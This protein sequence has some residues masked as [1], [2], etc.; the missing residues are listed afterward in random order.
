MTETSSTAQANKSQ[1]QFTLASLFVLTLLVACILSLYRC[2]GPAYGLVSAIPLGIIAVLLLRTRW[3]CTIGTVI[4]SVI[5]PLVGLY[6]IIGFDRSD[7]RFLKAV[8]TLGSFGGAFG[9][10]LHAII[11][12]RWIIGSILLAVSIIVFVAILVNAIPAAPS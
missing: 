4:G 5:L 10:G 9:A 6:L 7:P 2:L 12:K 8:V 3:H 11:L 1:Y